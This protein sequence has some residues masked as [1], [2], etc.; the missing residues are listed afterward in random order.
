MIVNAD[1]RTGISEYI[2]INM[3]KYNSHTHVYSPMVGADKTLGSIVLFFY[4]AL[5]KKK[6]SVHLLIFC[7]FSP[8]MTFQHISGKVTLDPGIAVKSVQAITGS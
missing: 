1:L 3:Y 4:S 6:Y 5:I 2:P 8:P 7:K